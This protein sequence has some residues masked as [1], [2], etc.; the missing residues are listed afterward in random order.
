MNNAYLGINLLD[1]GINPALVFADLL[2]HHEQL[3]RKVATKNAALL[4]DF[5]LDSPVYFKVYGSDTTGI[6][7]ELERGCGL[8]AE[9]HLVQHA[10]REL[11]THTVTVV[12]EHLWPDQAP[13]ILEEL[14]ELSSRF[15]VTHRGR[16]K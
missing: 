11:F 12:Q 6:I 7:K 13:E 9:A 10:G 1:F 16:F 15:A 14:V 4:K 2:S 8:F 5:G 3:L